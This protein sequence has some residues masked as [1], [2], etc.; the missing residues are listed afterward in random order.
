MAYRD[1]NKE[2]QATRDRVRRYRGKQSD[3]TPSL[4]D[5][6]PLETLGPDEG[7]L[8]QV[9]WKCESC[10]KVIYHPSFDRSRPVEIRMRA[11]CLKCL[12]GW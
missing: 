9:A 5:V 4:K 2:R 11:Q 8:H 1:K 10:G 7:G 12:R 3:V 6:T